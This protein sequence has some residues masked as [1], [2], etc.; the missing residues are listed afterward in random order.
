MEIYSYNKATNCNEGL[1]RIFNPNRYRVGMS[2]ECNN[3]QQA[4]VEGVKR[5]GRE[6]AFLHGISSPAGS[7]VAGGR[8]LSAHQ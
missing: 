5:Y 4:D 1:R 3:E 8:Y 7:P 2:L 6:A